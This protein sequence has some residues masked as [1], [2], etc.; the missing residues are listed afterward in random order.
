MLQEKKW[1]WKLILLKKI[2]DLHK[3]GVLVIASCK[4]YMAGMMVEWV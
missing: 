2:S 3:P 4:Q 1:V